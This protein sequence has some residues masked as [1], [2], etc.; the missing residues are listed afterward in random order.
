M[1]SPQ[2]KVKQCDGPCGRSKSQGK[3]L[4]AQWRKGMTAA[5]AAAEAAEAEAAA[6]AAA[7]AAKA[8]AA[9]A[10]TADKAVM[11][12]AVRQLCLDCSRPI[13]TCPS[14]KAMEANELDVCVASNE[15]APPNFSSPCRGGT[16]QKTK[17]ASNCGLNDFT[18]SPLLPPPSLPPLACSTAPLKKCKGGCAGNFR[19][20]LAFAVKAYR[21]TAQKLGEMARDPD[22]G[23]RKFAKS[24]LAQ[25]WDMCLPFYGVLMCRADNPSNGFVFWSLNCS[26]DCS[27]GTRCS[28][29]ASWIVRQEIKFSIK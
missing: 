15:N 13:V 22:A 27:P 12:S 10:L 3:Y 29:C 14:D 17:P 5:A 2:V 4:F 7:A 24:T 8:L 11:A 28:S 16:S 20:A 25:S 1:P 6:E 21:N 23:L 26:G 19:F 9:R 18:L